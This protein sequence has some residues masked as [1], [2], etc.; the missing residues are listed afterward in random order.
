MYKSLADRKAEFLKSH[1]AISDYLDDIPGEVASRA[2]HNVSFSPEQR[3]FEIQAE[4][5]L[6]ISEQ[7][8]RVISEIELAIGRGATIT[9]GWPV[10]VELWFELYRKRM[11]AL[12][13][14]YLAT[15]A[16]CA[17]PMITGP[18]RFPVERQRKQNQSA[19]N[20]YANLVSYAEH[21]P[22]RFL[23]RIM[24]FGNGKS[25]TSNAPNTTEMLVAKL[26]EH[27]KCQSEMKEANK[28]VSRFFKKGSAA[29]VTEAMRDE[30]A[31]QLMAVLKV[32]LPSAHQVL[33]PNG[34]SGKIIAFWPYQLAN[35][36]QE[37]R[38]LEQRIKEVEALHKATL[39]IAQTLEN[40]I[41]IR[42]SDDGKIEI[43]FGYKPDPVTRDYLVLK[44]FKFS[45]YRNNAWVRRIS[46]NAVVVFNRDVK[47][48]LE[49]LPKYRQN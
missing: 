4:H 44:S 32:D 8:I 22:T 19:D 25:I 11:I 21:S 46:T 9:A 48:M 12:C 39:G 6:R 7:K 17:S 42:K 28:I 40:G 15:M 38:R 27:I 33:K 23:K 45:R 26:N 13:L 30:C 18:A 20:K 43:H 2:F 47:P 31:R 10:E 5:A 49:R 3:G 34:Y 36:N 14:G 24:P 35:N 16:T 1:P 41:E 29:G 37:I